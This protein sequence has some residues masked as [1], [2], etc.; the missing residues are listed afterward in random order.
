MP[1]SSRPISIGAGDTL[2]FQAV[3][4]DGATRYNFQSL[5][6]Q[7]FAMFGGSGIP[8]VYQSVGLAAAADGVFVNG[9]GIDTVKT[10]GLRGAYNHNW[11]PYWNSALY[12][13]YAQLQYG[14]AGKG[15]IC[16]GL[17]GGN[18]WGSTSPAGYHQL[19]PGLQRG[20]DRRYHPLDTGEEPDVLGGHDLYPS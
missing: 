6:P 1:C 7:S 19:Q 4:T 10:W 13:A 5:A 15:F 11:D 12:G 16:G 8:G 20:P 3:Y 17:T 18:R 14:D 2:N 9:S